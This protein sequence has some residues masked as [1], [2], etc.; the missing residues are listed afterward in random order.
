MQHF[1]ECPRD[2]DESAECRC[3]DP[4]LYLGSEVTEEDVRHLD[5]LILG[6]KCGNDGLLSMPGVEWVRNKLAAH[7]GVPVR[8]LGWDLREEQDAAA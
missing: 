7:A 6:E 2:R 4:D 1:R 8:P 3:T 5:E